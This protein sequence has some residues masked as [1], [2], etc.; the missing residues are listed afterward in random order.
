MPVESD[1][2]D[3]TISPV[4]AKRNDPDGRPNYS[5]SDGV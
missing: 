4:R 5:T 1:A 3:I 2:V